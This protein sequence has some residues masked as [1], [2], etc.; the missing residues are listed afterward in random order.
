[1]GDRNFHQSGNSSPK[2]VK[3]LPDG[4]TWSTVPGCGQSSPACTLNN[5]AALAVD[6]AGN[7]YLADRGVPEVLKVS[8]NGSTWTV[9]G[10]G[11]VQVTGYSVDT[12]GILTFT[13]A[14]GCGLAAGSSVTVAGTDGNGNAYYFDGTYTINSASATEFSVANSGFAPDDGS[15][16]LTGVTAF[17]SNTPQPLGVAADGAGNVY[18]ADANSNLLVEL[19]RRDAPALTFA[20]TVVGVNSLQNLTVSNDGNQ[21]LN[22]SGITGGSTLAPGTGT[23]A[24]STGSATLVAG[25]CEVYISPENHGQSP[26]RFDNPQ[27]QCVELTPGN[28]GCR[29]RDASGVGIWQPLGGADD[30]VRSGLDNGERHC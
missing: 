17:N 19:D 6:A 28:Y 11:T 7:L 23:T 9:A 20:S 4:V 25:V 18:I 3:V 22:F 26:Q 5:L 15:T 12:N 21:S 16:T 24:C 10:M 1:M 13:C 30:Y 27:R 2:I 29:R 8:P 14:N